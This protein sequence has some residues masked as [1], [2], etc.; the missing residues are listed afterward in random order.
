MDADA[1]WGY[2]VN[3]IST[4]SCPALTSTT[5]RWRH[6]LRRLNQQ[7]YRPS[8]GRTRTFSCFTAGIPFLR[9]RYWAAHFGGN[10]ASVMLPHSRRYRL[11]RTS[12]FSRTTG[13]FQWVD[14]RDHRR[15]KVRKLEQST[16]YRPQR[17]ALQNEVLNAVSQHAFVLFTCGLLPQLPFPRRCLISISKKQWN[18]WFSCGWQY[19]HPKRLVCARLLLPHVT[20]D[21]HKVR[22]RR[23]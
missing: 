21:P 10:A 19:S 11:P 14:G 18:L 7:G 17:S 2:Q 5:L 3:A 15:T 9:V 22:W 8:P 6:R 13:F 4:V 23:G 12:P 1:K 20:S 16:R